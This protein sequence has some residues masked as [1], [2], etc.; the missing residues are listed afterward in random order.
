MSL[1]PLKFQPGLNRELT[2][3]SNEGGW[4]DMDKVRFRF[5]FPEKIAGWVKRSTSQK[6]IGR[7]RALISWVDLRKERY[8]GIGTNL[9]YYIDRGTT[10][11]DITP[12]RQV[13]TKKDVV[14]IVVNYSAGSTGLPPLESSVAD[15]T[16]SIGPISVTGVFATG[17]AGSIV[18]NTDGTP[19]PQGSVVIKNLDGVSASG[20]VGSPVGIADDIFNFYVTGVSADSSLGSVFL[21][22]T[23]EEDD[24][25][26]AVVSGSR[27][28]TVTTTTEHGAVTGD[29]VTFSNVE[30]SPGGFDVATAAVVNQEYVVTKISNFQFSFKLR[31]ADKTIKDITVNGEV[32]QDLFP[33]TSTVTT[34]TGGGTEARAEL[35]ENVGSN[36]SQLFNGWNAGPW[37][38]QGWGQTEAQ[39]SLRLWHHTTFG[40]DLILHYRDGPIYY[41]DASEDVTTRAVSLTGLTGATKT[42]T[43][44][45]Q[46][47]VSDRD[48]HIIAFGCDP[49]FDPGVQ[50]PLTIRFSTSDEINPENNLRR[51][52]TDPE[53]TAGELRLG[54]GS[55]IVQAVETKQQILVFTDTTLYTMQFL[56][57]PYI[58]GVSA[59]SE[60]ITIQSPNA[61]VAVDDVVMWMGAN[62]FYVYQG[63]VQRMPCTVRDYIFN[64]FNFDQ[65]EKVIAGVNSEHSEV[66]WFYPSADFDG[67]G[68]YQ[69]EDVDR[70][71]IYNYQEQTWSVGTL[72]RTA[73]MDRGLFNFPI[74]AG[75]DGHLYEHEKGFDDGSYEPA[76]AIA[77]YIESSPFDIGEGDKFMMIKKLIP[78]VTFKDS[79]SVS[80]YVNLGL[81]TEQYPGDTRVPL[82]SYN[83]WLRAPDDMNDV[84]AVSI[85]NAANFV[86]ADLALWGPTHQAIPGRILGDITNGGETERPTYNDSLAMNTYINWKYYDNP[87]KPSSDQID[88]IENY[89]APYMEARP[90]IFVNIV[91]LYSSNLGQRLY[92]N[93]NATSQ[94]YK[95]YKLPAL[96]QLYPDNEA[97]TDYV[98]VRLRGRSATFKISSN[99]LGVGWRLGTPKLEVRE[100]GRR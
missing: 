34:T 49:E 31:E 2:R 71:V 12:I 88:Y 28:V 98:N 96:P 11:F 29:F 24:L 69:N 33:F 8:I 66:W 27:E 5:G 100:S 61:A 65:A 15:V 54:L 60:K 9:K 95:T 25:T 73:W 64:D 93:N 75:T 51:W 83:P 23:D 48:R 63:S 56:G 92:D 17:S 44:A 41:W 62:E 91:E 82:N 22:T 38:S 80:P 20:F 86:T 7:C 18:S 94:I 3:S 99:E 59:V 16:V 74:A 1:I 42:P 97:F 40:E 39:A 87:N 13:F 76:R 89:M 90:D 37:G 21:T 81:R 43:I 6:F 53:T 72:N 26:F 45:K 79:N 32:D 35:Q 84:T 46:V 58:F 47:L 85:L 4:Y 70:Y 19:L 55:Q 50:D 78:D 57:P 36:I 77:A 68:T 52:D 67:Q 10:L 30:P 14:S